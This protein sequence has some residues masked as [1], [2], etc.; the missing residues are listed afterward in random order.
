VVVIVVM[1]VK[2]VKMVMMVMM[3]VV[4]TYHSLYLNNCQYSLKKTKRKHTWAQDVN[5]S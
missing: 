3:V 1:V 4:S 5:A 2:M